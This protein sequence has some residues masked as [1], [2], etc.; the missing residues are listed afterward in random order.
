MVLLF[1]FWLVRLRVVGR[2]E[3]DF[4][5]IKTFYRCDPYACIRGDGMAQ[6]TDTKSVD[7][8]I[9]D[10]NG[11]CS[12]LQWR[13]HQPKQSSTLAL[14]GRESRL[15]GLIQASPGDDVLLCDIPMQANRSTLMQL[16]DS[17][18]QIQYLSHQIG[19][20]SL[21]HPQLQYIEDAPQD[22]CTSLMVDRILDGK[23]RQW[24]LV[25]AYGKRCNA[26]ADKLASSVGLPAHERARLRELGELINYNACSVDGQNACIPPVDLYSLMSGYQQAMDFLQSES[27]ASEL[28]SVRREDLE[29]AE[30]IAPYWQDAHASVYVLPDTPWAHRVAGGLGT[31]L[32]AN[33]PTRAH[34][35]LRPA[36][37]GCF[38][39]RVHAA[40]N[41]PNGGLTFTDAQ[42][43]DD[44]Q[45]AWV[46][47]HLP[48][49]EIDHFISAFSACRWGQLR[50]PFFR[51]RH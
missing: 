9:G 36:A 48:D 40:R 28:E 51:A 31:H 38:M 2:F 24:A 11:L 39:T 13:L 49:Q 18:A 7:I 50:T 3:F 37:N 47:E 26:S 45:R 15:D 17:G 1:G 42:A 12:L 32:S 46:I 19:E 5:Q 44:C 29:R 41:N 6:K 20:E 34:A 23:Y 10:A 43:D 22:S 8:C 30:Q 27:V 25:G 4:S 21:W 35:F 14:L 16:L 33:E